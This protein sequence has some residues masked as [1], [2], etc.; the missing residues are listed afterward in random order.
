MR[1]CWTRLVLLFSFLC[2][3]L[4]SSADANSNCASCNS[5]SGQPE[6]ADKLRSI[7]N[8][9]TYQTNIN[10]MFTSSALL[11]FSERCENFVGEEGLGKWGMAIINE[12]HRERFDAL[13]NGTNDLIEICPGFKTLDDESK[14]LVWVMIVNAMVH[15]ESSCNNNEVARGPNGAVVGLLQLHQNRE[16]RYSEGCNRGDART[17][18]GSLSCGLSMLNKQLQYDEAL[19]SR[20]S[21]WDVL[22]P[23]ARSRKYLKVKESV[24]NLTFCR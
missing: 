8:T 9:I 18:S 11:N 17:D 21:Y 23:Q 6:F 20:K 7:R 15:L 12:M 22:R 10:Q 14:E 2:F 4:V 19:F 5:S 3:A 24:Q 1:T 13:Y 16:H